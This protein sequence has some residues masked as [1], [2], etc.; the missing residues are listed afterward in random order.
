MTE[1]LSMVS[2][3]VASEQ[4]DGMIV[5]TFNKDNTS[6]DYLVGQLNMA[7]VSHVLQCLLVN[8]VLLTQIDFRDLET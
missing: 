7:E 2:A 3:K 1:C 8:N 4:V 6:E 5:I